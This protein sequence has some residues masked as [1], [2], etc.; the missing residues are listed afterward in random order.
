METRCRWEYET[1][2]CGPYSFVAAVSW[3]LI[4]ILFFC[5]RRLLAVEISL[6]LYT[7]LPF[8]RDCSDVVDASHRPNQDK[9]LYPPLFATTPTLLLSWRYRRDMGRCGPTFCRDHQPGPMWTHIV[10]RSSVALCWELRL[11]SDQRHAVLSRWGV[12]VAAI[13]AAVLAPLYRQL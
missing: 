12:G 2:C 13:T 9:A 5:G 4:L 3:P 6:S 1:V 7:L 11:L 8:T 10:P